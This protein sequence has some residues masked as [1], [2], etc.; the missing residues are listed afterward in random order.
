M[1]GVLICSGS[2]FLFDNVE[3]LRITLPLVKHNSYDHMCVVHYADEVN[4]TNLLNLMPTRLDRVIEPRLCYWYRLDQIG[5][6]IFARIKMMGIEVHIASI[7]GENKSKAEMEEVFPRDFV[8][9]MLFHMSAAESEYFDDPAEITKLIN[10]CERH[11][12]SDADN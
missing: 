11:K 8:E 2:R 1:R 4:V 7:R 12:W 10:S 9:E 5:S 6:I 3:V